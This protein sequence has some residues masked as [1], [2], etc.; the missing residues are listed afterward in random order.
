MFNDSYRFKTAVFSLFISF[1]FSALSFSQSKKEKAAFLK[2][3]V[4][5]MQVKLVRPQFRID[6]RSVFF[7]GQSLNI[8]GFDAG[9]LLKNKLRL[10]LGYYSLNNELSS[11][12]KTIENVE[13]NRQLKLQY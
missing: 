11:Y 8:N 13:Y 10:T 1:V 2:D 6:N 7:K 9:V 4:H 12:N 5:I 3:S